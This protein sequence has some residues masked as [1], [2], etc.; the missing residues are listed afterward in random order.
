MHN[1]TRKPVR[2][3]SGAKRADELICTLRESLGSISRNLNW[4]LVGLQ[5]FVGGEV[6]GDSHFNWAVFIGGT[7]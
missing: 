7:L 5:P 4:F 3:P 1:R 2:R 6:H